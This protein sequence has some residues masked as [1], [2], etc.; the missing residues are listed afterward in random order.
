[1]RTRSVISLNFCSPLISNP[2]GN[3]TLRIF[4]TL[5]QSSPRAWLFLLRRV[6]L[7]LNLRASLGRVML[8]PYVLS[9]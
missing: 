2:W 4:P 8:M 5:R 6:A 9:S 3:I 7:R 1:M